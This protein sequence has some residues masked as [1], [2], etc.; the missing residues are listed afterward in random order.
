MPGCAGTGQCSVHPEFC[1]PRSLF[2]TFVPI[3]LHHPQ[4]QQP[5]KPPQPPG[6][7]SAVPGSLQGA[8]FCPGCPWQLALPMPMARAPAVPRSSHGFVCQG[9]CQ[10]PVAPPGMESRLREGWWLWAGLAQLPPACPCPCRNEVTKMKFEGKTFYL[11]VSQKE[12]S[13]AL[14]R[15]IL[16]TAGSRDRG[17]SITWHGGTR[18]QQLQLCATA[19]VTSCSCC[20]PDVGTGPQSPLSPRPGTRGLCQGPQLLAMPSL[21]SFPR[22]FFIAI[23]PQRQPGLLCLGLAPQEPS[24]GIFKPPCFWLFPKAGSRVGTPAHPSCQVLHQADPSIPSGSRAGPVRASA[25]LQLCLL[26]S[27]SV[28]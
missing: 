2:S 19:G 26:L 4:V 25:S 23:V 13:A 17:S 3:K 15:D 8:R 20:C 27:L 5:P 22:C 11:Y 14:P 21:G 18:A 7:F 12:V 9:C 16:G 6:A 24:A 1:C 28:G 10:R